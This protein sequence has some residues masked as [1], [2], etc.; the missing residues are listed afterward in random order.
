MS[1][2]APDQPARPGLLSGW[3]WLILAC[4]LILIIAAAA[5][6]RIEDRRQ[7]VQ[8]AIVM[9]GGDPSGAPELLR[10]FG[11]AGCHTISGVAGA[12]GKVGPPLDQLRER[13][14][15]AGHLANT[16]DNLIN[17]IISP[18]SFAPH[19]AMP[20]TGISKEEARQIAAFLYSR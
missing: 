11:C 5:T 6:T 18:Q 14:F 1:P 2:A 4:A 12:D 9:T 15:I 19:A 16:P 8:A 17:W 20:V 10:R 3:Q 13:V 7:R